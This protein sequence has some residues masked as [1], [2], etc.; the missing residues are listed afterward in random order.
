MKNTLY[1]AGIIA[2]NII[3]I[4]SS[5]FFKL[6]ITEPLIK[7]TDIIDSLGIEILIGLILSFFGFALAYFIKSFKPF[8]IG[9]TATAISVCIFLL[10]YLNSVV[11]LKSSYENLRVREVNCYND[12]FFLNIEF[13]Q[14]YNT[15]DVPP[16]KSLFVDS[17]LVRID[18]GIFGMRKMTNNIR[19]IENNTCSDTIISSS[20]V[21]EYLKASELFTQKRCFT[22]AFTLY[23]K[24]IQLDSLNSEIY[25][26]RAKLF[27]EVNRFKEALSDIT[28]WA[29][30]TAHTYDHNI[31]HLNLDKSA[32]NNSIDNQ[33]YD[34]IEKFI[35]FLSTK[36]KY[37]MQN[38]W[39]EFCL[40]K[41]NYDTAN[42]AYK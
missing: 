9:L 19:I 27:L 21:N 28:Y 42:T 16:D 1:I 12:Q 36:K 37:T 14:W 35:Q 6:V 20:N 23:S 4:F 34:D 2:V 38:K 3:L 11:I 39:L 15:I 33:Q 7:S 5:L 26:N 8:A 41:I 10:F 25:F 24:S 29:I 17:V 31:I 22:R 13:N 18:H 40:S 30:L 32:L